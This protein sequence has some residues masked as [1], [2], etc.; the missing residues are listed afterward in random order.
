MV[1]I[2]CLSIHVLSPD[3]L[4][5]GGGS[6]TSTIDYRYVL[7]LTVGAALLYFA[8][9]LLVRRLRGIAS[10]PSVIGSLLVGGIVGTAYRAMHADALTSWVPVVALVYLLFLNEVTRVHDAWARR[11][12]EHELQRRKARLEADD[13]RSLESLQAELQSVQRDLERERAPEPCERALAMRALREAKDELRDVR[14][15]RNAE[16]RRA[17]RGLREAAR[18]APQVTPPGE[19]NS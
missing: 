14:S 11:K 13:A 2:A 12:I 7:L 9:T 8:L 15:A 10:T 16:R 6:S 1:E 17:A 4:G 19:G 5:I 18:R 3:V